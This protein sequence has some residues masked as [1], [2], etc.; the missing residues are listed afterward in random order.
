MTDHFRYFNSS[1]AVIRLT[2]MMYVRFP[3]SLCNVEELL[4]ER[5]FDV[6]YET[7]RFWW[8][9]FGPVFAKEIR[10]RRLK[11]PVRHSSWRWHIDEVFVKINGESHYLW[12]AVD[13]EGEM[14]DAVITK[15]R[16]KQAA[17]KVLKS[18][19]KR[20]G[21]LAE[22]VTDRLGSYGA[23]LQDRDAKHLQEVGRWLNNSAENSHLVFRR[24]ERAMNK[25]RSEETL[26]KFTSTQSQFYKHF[27]GE[28][29]LTKRHQYR[30]FRS[31]ALSEW[32][33]V[34]V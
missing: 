21:H 31:E 11:Y 33:S 27:N 24:R 18:L 7:V 20:Y 2:V 32:Q 14:L 29:H 10:K 28:G 34:A 30:K 13:H 12:R 4:F 3:L 26:Q 17:L 15:R 5:G 22:I 16:N 9:R 8:N 23:A 1:P 6:C 19:M 25:F